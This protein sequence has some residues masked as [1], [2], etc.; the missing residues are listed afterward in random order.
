MTP[1]RIIEQ[2]FH[3]PD[4]H[5][6]D[7]A[8]LQKLVTEYPYFSTARV[9]LAKKDYS[10]H[11]NLGSHAVKTGSLYSLP[12]HHYY[13]FITASPVLMEIEE[14]LPAILPDY[15]IRVP[16]VEKPAETQEVAAAF[17]APEDAEIALSESAALPPEM[18]TEAQEEP[19]ADELNAGLAPEAPVAE[20]PEV[21]YPKVHVVMPSANTGGIQQIDLLQARVAAE[22]AAA[23]PLP[24]YIGSEIQAAAPA[25]IMEAAAK[26]DQPAEEQQISADAP[27]ASMEGPVALTEENKETAQHIAPVA[28]PEMSDTPVNAPEAETA[29]EGTAHASGETEPIRIFPL[30]LPTEEAT[31]L[32]FQ[33]LFA[34]DYFA[35]K[36]LKNPDEADELNKQGEADMKSFTSWLRQIKD[37]FTG[38]NSKDWYHQQ[39]NKIYDEDTEPEIS[40][41]VE[42]MAM[43]SIIINNDIVSETLAEIWVRQQQYQNAIQIYK[44]LSLL[45]PDKNAYFAQKIK[46][47]KSLTDKNK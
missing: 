37:N 27:A 35:Y 28:V 46:E 34:D 7:E 3:V 4:L 32:V 5:Q 20:E 19:L 31:E 25:E 23:S 16:V 8:A 17:H 30:E 6:V 11:S 29:V 14:R 41:T 10:R 26:V 43:N 38:R 24:D 9:L 44:K 21:H 12:A 42:K 36:R 2:L 18:H 1:N 22:E 33:P 13:H 45:N 47:L 15:D 40:E 39:L